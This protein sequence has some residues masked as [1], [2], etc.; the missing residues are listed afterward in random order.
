[1]CARVCAHT[2]F[3]IYQICQKHLFLSKGRTHGSRNHGKDS[4][5]VKASIP[6]YP[7]LFFKRGKKPPKT[8]HM[9][10]SQHVV[11]PPKAFIYERV[12]ICLLSL[13]NGCLTCTGCE[14]LSIPGV[15]SSHSPPFRNTYVE[16]QCQIIGSEFLKMLQVQLFK[17]SN[18]MPRAIQNEGAGDWPDLCRCFCY[19]FKKK[20]WLGNKNT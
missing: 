14:K 1:M 3:S 8:K 20:C 12:S 9:K 2:Q 16:F 18:S 10:V 6:P 5:S 15:W 11:R 19:K 17:D 13:R 7:V 4:D